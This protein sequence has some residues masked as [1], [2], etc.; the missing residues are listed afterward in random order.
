MKNI[1]K[2]SPNTNQWYA[3]Y[4][5]MPINIDNDEYLRMSEDDII[6]IIKNH[7]KQEPKQSEDKFLSPDEAEEGFSNM[8]KQLGM[9]PYDPN[10]KGTFKK[11]IKGRLREV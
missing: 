5:G 11:F 3:N 7:T 2:F 4:K 9:P 1:F 6:Q 10:K 8:R